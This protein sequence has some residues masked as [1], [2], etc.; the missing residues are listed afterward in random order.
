[1]WAS[2]FRIARFLFPKPPRHAYPIG[3]GRQRL[4]AKPGPTTATMAYRP[5]PDYTDASG[6]AF[7][8]TGSDGHTAVFHRIGNVPEPGPLGCNNATMTMDAVS[9][10]VDP[11][12]WYP[13]LYRN[14]GGWPDAD[15][16]GAP[17]LVGDA[18]FPEGD[19]PG[20]VAAMRSQWLAAGDSA[21]QPPAPISADWFRAERDSAV[22]NDNTLRAFHRRTELGFQNGTVPAARREVGHVL[23]T[24]VFATVVMPEFTPVLD[25]PIGA[26]R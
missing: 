4:T 9:E 5:H 1:M 11:Q 16:D 7:V 25:T 12:N 8:R 22:K 20:L 21:T 3:T 6:L 10:A 17:S 24:S 13:D 15:G 26:T 19:I 23:N 2:V 18:H 14:A